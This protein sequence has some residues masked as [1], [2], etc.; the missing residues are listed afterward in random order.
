M[1]K[2]WQWI[3]LETAIAI[4]EEQ[5]IQHGGGIGTRDPALLESALA[6]PQQM[7]AYTDAD[8]HDLAAAYAFG[9]SRN[10]PFIDGNKRTA[11]IAA[12]VFLMLHGF[13][14]T[15]DDTQCYLNMLSLAAGD[16]T[17]EAFAEWLR[18]NTVKR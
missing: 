9:I 10:H 1:T 6:R 8:V 17:Q 11:W 18:G 4:H 2:T 14:R 7:A 5:L 16:T 13:D 12:R 3:T 15:A